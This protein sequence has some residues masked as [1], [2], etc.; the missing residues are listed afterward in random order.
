MKNSKEDLKY[1]N[2]PIYQ[3]HNFYE[4]AI[5]KQAFAGD[6]NFIPRDFSIKISN[7]SLDNLTIL[8]EDIIEQNKSPNNYNSKL[9]SLII[10]SKF[11]LANLL[12]LVEI[13]SLLSS[14]NYIKF[15]IPLERKLFDK[16]IEELN[17]IERVKFFFDEEFKTI[18]LDLQNPISFKINFTNDLDSTNESLRDQNMLSIRSQEDYLR[19][20]KFK[21]LHKMEIELDD[22]DRIIYP[23][24]DLNYNNADLYRNSPNQLENIGNIESKG[25]N[26]KKNTKKNIADYQ[27]VNEEISGKS[28]SKNINTNFARS[29]AQ[30]FETKIPTNRMALIKSISE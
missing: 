21:P 24:I 13:I 9:N 4:K 2:L 28:K 26:N 11:D 16:L 20:N 14:L 17:F 15:E 6:R 10:D 22:Q 7:L 1:E 29:Y 5:I 25:F 12:K 23:I 3:F 18:N 30:L 19:I 27:S 8:L